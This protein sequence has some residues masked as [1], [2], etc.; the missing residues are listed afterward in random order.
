MHTNQN[1]SEQ[2]PE[3][4]QEQMIKEIYEETQK[5]KRLVKWQLY[6]TLVLVVLPLLA[7]LAILPLVLKTLAAGNIVPM[8][9]LQ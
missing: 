6:V 2:K 9:G 3:L 1:P 5:T 7:L 8:Q 4:T